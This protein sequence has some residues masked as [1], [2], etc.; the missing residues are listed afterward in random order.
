M[1][2]PSGA[3]YVIVLIGSGPQNQAKYDRLIE[4]FQHA[5]CAVYVEVAGD[6][7]WTCPGW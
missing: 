6:D 3:D 2:P 1:M 5:S 7:A 4:F